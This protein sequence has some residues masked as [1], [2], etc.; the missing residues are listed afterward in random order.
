MGR[1]YVPSLG[2]QTV[3]GLGR[4]GTI[5][6]GVASGETLIYN[7]ADVMIERGHWM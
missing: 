1:R 2:W 7:G 4:A 5:A 6:F 3:A